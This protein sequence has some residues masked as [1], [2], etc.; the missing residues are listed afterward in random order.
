MRIQW[1]GL[2]GPVRG[3]LSQD[4]TPAMQEYTWIAILRAFFRTIPEQEIYYNFLFR[5][6]P[7]EC[8]KDGNPGVF[9]P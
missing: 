2:T 1:Q 5:N 7:E 8:S 4:H 6:G 3:R 9:L